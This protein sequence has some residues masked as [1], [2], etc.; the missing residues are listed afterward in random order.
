MRI[1]HSGELLVPKDSRA[2]RFLADVPEAGELVLAEYSLSS[3][4]PQF[5]SRNQASRLLV[6]T[7]LQARV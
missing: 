4:S 5:S 3:N 7:T 6:S 1:D 2:L